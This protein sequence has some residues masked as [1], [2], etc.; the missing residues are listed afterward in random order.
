MH[1]RLYRTDCGRPLNGKQSSCRW[2]CDLHQFDSSSQECLTVAISDDVQVPT[3][4]AAASW[5][6]RSC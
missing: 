4:S 2:K 3:L 5:K 1:L 6:P